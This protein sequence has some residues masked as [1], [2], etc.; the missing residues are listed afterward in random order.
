MSGFFLELFTEEIPA[1]LQSS[2]RNDLNK[3]FKIFFDQQNIKYDIK[4]INSSK[5]PKRPVLAKVSKY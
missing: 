5:N 4:Y 1:G 3:N 2:A